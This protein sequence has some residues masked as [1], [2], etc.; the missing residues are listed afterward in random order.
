MLFFNTNNS[1]M[2]DKVHQCETENGYFCKRPP[3]YIV[4]MKGGR[5]RYSCGVHS[6]GKRRS[7]ISFSG[8]IKQKLTARVNKE[9]FCPIHIE[10]T[11]DTVTHQLCFD[12]EHGESKSAQENRDSS[13]KNLNVEPLTEQDLAY[14]LN[15]MSHSKM[16]L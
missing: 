4:Y 7:S 5:T 16:E 6:K 13:L 12:I 10:M 14:I 8:G 2:S 3:K 9:L 15:Y 1:R 11:E